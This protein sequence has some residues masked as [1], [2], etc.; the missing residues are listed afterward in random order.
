MSRSHPDHD[1]PLFLVDTV[2]SQG[3]SDVSNNEQWQQQLRPRRALTR[4]AYTDYLL[5]DT[6]SMEATEAQVSLT[7]PF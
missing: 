3:I 7:P 2:P 4:D 5:L 1:P 6:L